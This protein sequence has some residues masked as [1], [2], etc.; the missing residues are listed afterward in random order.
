[1]MIFSPLRS[2]INDLNSKRGSNG[3]C[4]LLVSHKGLGQFDVI[5]NKIVIDYLYIDWSSCFIPLSI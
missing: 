3:N 1:M 4:E 5:E 2:K